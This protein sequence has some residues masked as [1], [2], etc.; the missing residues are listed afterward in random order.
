MRCLNHS[1]RRN[2]GN[3]KIKATARFSGCGNAL[4]EWI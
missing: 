3:K 4:D 1:Q 2:L